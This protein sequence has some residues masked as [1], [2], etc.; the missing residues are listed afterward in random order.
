MKGVS[1]GVLTVGGWCACNCTTAADAAMVWQEGGLLE[2]VEAAGGW[3]TVMGRVAELG[4]KTLDMRC[5]LL[6]CSSLLSRVLLA[7]TYQ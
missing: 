6:S 7:N 1:L 4:W 2:R 5:R 3:E